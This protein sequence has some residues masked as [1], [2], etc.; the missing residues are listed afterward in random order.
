MDVVGSH[1]YV[2]VP[3]AGLVIFN[4]SFWPSVGVQPVGALIVNVP[5]ALAVTLVKSKLHGGVT[6]AA[7]VAVFIRWKICLQFAA[8]EL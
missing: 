1:E 3:P 4:S 8:H 7:E 5:V 2:T 6:D